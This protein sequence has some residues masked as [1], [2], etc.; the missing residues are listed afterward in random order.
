LPKVLAQRQLGSSKG[1]EFPGIQLRARSGWMTPAFSIPQQ[2]S[3]EGSQM[4]LLPQCAEDDQFLAK[5]TFMRYLVLM[6]FMMHRLWKLPGE[7]VEANRKGIPQDSFSGCHPFEQH[8]HMSSKLAEAR[9]LPARFFWA[10]CLFIQTEGV[11]LA[12]YFGVSA[13][14]DNFTIFFVRD[15]CFCK[16]VTSV[17]LYT[18]SLASFLP[19]AAFAYHFQHRW[20]EGKPWNPMRSEHCYDSKLFFIATM[21]FITVMFFIMRLK[22][23]EAIGWY[24]T[25]DALLHDI[26][27]VKVSLAICVPPL[28]DFIQSLMLVTAAKLRVH[29]F[30]R[31]H[32]HL[33]PTVA[34]HDGLDTQYHVLCGGSSTVLQQQVQ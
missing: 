26:G 9:W 20:Y 14:M 15:L 31:A 29:A 4:P 23:I 1:P 8:P 28:I 24:A 30:R 22:L 32:E 2:N 13:L 19:T 33:L 17:A 18:M 25:V 21:I 10:G 3:L 5:W 34:I 27:T 16:Y 12:V 7:C 11:G 6:L